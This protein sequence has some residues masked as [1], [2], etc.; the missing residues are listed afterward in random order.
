M[1][2]NRSDSKA[3]DQP[4]QPKLT[5]GERT[6]QRLMDVAEKLFAEHGYEGASL[7]DIASAAKIREPGIYNHFAG[8]AALY[9]AALERALGP[10]L[11]L[12]EAFDSDNPEVNAETLPGLMTDLLAEHPHMPA[13]F[14]QALSSSETD[15]AHAL[16]REWLNK[17]FAGGRR[18]MGGTAKTPEL[19]RREAVRMV[20]M[21]NVCTGYFLSQRVM[22]F[23]GAGELLSEENLAAQ[24]QLLTEVVGL[25][26]KSRLPY[27]GFD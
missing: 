5:K 17:L 22:D 19:Q 10:M 14:Q 21:F 4:V 16:M 3:T 1:T 11:A 7:R 18:T 23:M 26:A 2:K 24:K 15:P 12:L 6:A 8:K 27:A 9:S 20:A 25:F 13:L